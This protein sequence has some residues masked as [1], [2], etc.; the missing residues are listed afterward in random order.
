MAIVDL[1]YD[2]DDHPAFRPS[3]YG[4]NLDRSRRLPTVL[5]SPEA[6]GFH[7]Y[8]PGLCSRDHSHEGQCDLPDKE[9]R[10]CLT[11]RLR[12][13]ERMTFPQGSSLH[14]AMQPGPYHHPVSRMFGVWSLRIPI[15]SCLGFLR[16][17]VSVISAISISP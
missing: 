8:Q 15:R 12:A 7:R 4:V 13:A 6:L 11:Q 2:S 1:S 16:F 10:L 17:I 9:F 3:R 14:V 5:P